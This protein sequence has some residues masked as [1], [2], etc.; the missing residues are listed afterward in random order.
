MP[1]AEEYC[2]GLESSV[3]DLANVAHGAGRAGSIDAA[4]FL[5]E[6]AG[7]RRWAHLDIAGPARAAADDGEITKG[8]TGF[9]AA[10]LLRWLS[11]DPLAGDPLASDALAGDA[12]GAA[13]AGASQPA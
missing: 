3:A 13:S 4:L 2:D 9:G 1:L 7:E 12:E 11:S 10:L 8:A 6:F 5:R